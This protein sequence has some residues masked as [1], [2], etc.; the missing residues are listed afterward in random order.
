MI[1]DCPSSCLRSCLIPPDCCVLWL[2]SLSR[3]WSSH[4]TGV[5]TCHE[6][7][8]TIHHTVTL[9]PS[10]ADVGIVLMSELSW[11]VFQGSSWFTLKVQC[12]Q[13]IIQAPVQDIKFKCWRQ[14]MTTN[15]LRII[16]LFPRLLQAYIF[17]VVDPKKK[18]NHQSCRFKNNRLKIVSI[19]RYI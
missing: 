5:V 11:L 4:I 13:F 14:R 2:L 17:W 12:Q 15:Q 1:Y 18:K 6:F 16:C 10:H 19:N 3:Q 9:S 8:V 7:C